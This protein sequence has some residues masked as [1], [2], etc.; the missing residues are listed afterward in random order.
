MLTVPRQSRGFSMNNKQVRK[1]DTFPP[2]D[3][4][5][6][7]VGGE[8]GQQERLY[9]TPLLTED[10]IDPQLRW[11][12]EGAMPWSVRQKLE[13]MGHQVQIHRRYAPFELQDGRIGV[14]PIDNVKITPVKL[15]NY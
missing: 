15:T 11:S 13:E 8:D 10:Q 3:M 4:I 14:L 9:P 5:T 7:V 12:G 2:Y 1:P 6:L